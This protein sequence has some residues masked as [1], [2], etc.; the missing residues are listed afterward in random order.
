MVTT[1]PLP[2]SFASQVSLT[3]KMRTAHFRGALTE[4]RGF[5][6]RNI[7]LARVQR[8][9]ADFAALYYILLCKYCEAI[10]CKHEKV[11]S[12][13]DQG[14]S[15]PRSGC[16]GTL[17]PRAPVTL[18][19]LLSHFILCAHSTAT[20]A[21]RRFAAGRANISHALSSLCGLRAHF[22]FL[23]CEAKTFHFCAVGTSYVFVYYYNYA[24]QTS[25]RVRRRVMDLR[26]DLDKCAAGN[27]CCIVKAY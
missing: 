24:G 15:A 10:S 18:P 19:V 4:K 26:A 6:W 12:R 13:H 17:P 3:R 9:A 16:S 1:P 23:L 5:R 11:T 2:P 25:I 20:F 21:M 7:T 22:T 8:H 27:T 14:W